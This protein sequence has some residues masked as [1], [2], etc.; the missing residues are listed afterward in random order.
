[1]PT[2]ASRSRSPACSRRSPYPPSRNSKFASSTTNRSVRN[3][4]DSLPNS[5]VSFLALGDTAANH[6]DPSQLAYEDKESGHSPQMC[7]KTGGTILIRQ[8]PHRAIGTDT[9]G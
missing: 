2:S 1:M 4:G 5:A 3:G 7:P 6:D 8:P 9:V